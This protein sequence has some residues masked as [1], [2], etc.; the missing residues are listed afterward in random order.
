L[1]AGPAV[2]TVAVLTRTTIARSHITI[3]VVVVMLSGPAVI[4]LR[5]T[6]ADD[7]RQSRTETAK[8]HSSVVYALHPVSRELDTLVER[9]YNN[10]YVCVRTLRFPVYF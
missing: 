8:Q 3:V 6:A 5:A 1:A 2:A 10:I 4:D 7:P 9:I